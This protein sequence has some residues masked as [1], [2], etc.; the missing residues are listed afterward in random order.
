MKIVVI[1]TCIDTGI[2]NNSSEVDL[3][4][5]RAILSEML[6]AATDHA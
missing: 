6:N 3:A 2:P 1:G 4:R 5:Y